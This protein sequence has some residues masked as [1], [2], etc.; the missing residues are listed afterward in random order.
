MKG[1]LVTGDRLLTWGQTYKGDV[2]CVF[3]RNHLESRDHIFLNADSA[4]DFGSSVCLG[5]E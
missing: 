5:A 2:N 1:R 3:C 4:I